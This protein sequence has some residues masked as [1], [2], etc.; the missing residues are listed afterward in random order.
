[1]EPEQVSKVNRFYKLI[2]IL[3]VRN[4]HMHLE[5]KCC[6]TSTLLF[7]ALMER[8]RPLVPERPR[9]TW[10]DHFTLYNLYHT[11]IFCFCNILV[12]IEF[13]GLILDSPKRR[14]HN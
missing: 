14:K 3:E 13:P 2:F 11:F 9:N 12:T 7:T 5:L 10:G 1:M 4:I 8:T 6:W